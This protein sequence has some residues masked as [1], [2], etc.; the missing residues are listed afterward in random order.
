MKGGLE[1]LRLDVKLS[2][3][4]K[5]EKDKINFPI[6]LSGK[7]KLVMSNFPIELSESISN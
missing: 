3:K 1:L 4:E 6:E 7:T 5:S 2:E